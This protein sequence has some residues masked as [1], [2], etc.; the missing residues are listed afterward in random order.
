MSFT[1]VKDPE[2]LGLPSLHSLDAVRGARRRQ[3]EAGV[4]PTPRFSRTSLQWLS[5]PLLFGYVT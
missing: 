3:A 1:L 4:V 2:R 5:F